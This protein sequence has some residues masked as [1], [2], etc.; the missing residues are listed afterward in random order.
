MKKKWL[1]LEWDA[2][3]NWILLK[4]WNKIAE[5]IARI[6]TGHIGLCVQLCGVIQI[7]FLPRSRLM[8]F[9][10]GLHPAG[11][12]G[13]ITNRMLRSLM[14]SHSLL[15]SSQPGFHACFFFFSLLSIFL[16]FAAN[17]GSASDCP[18]NLF[19]FWNYFWFL[20]L[21]WDIASV[22][23]PLW[24]CCDKQ[25][26]CGIMVWPNGLVCHVMSCV[27]EKWFCAFVCKI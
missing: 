18:P 20:V 9:Q 25:E 4:H 27:L 16:L 5:V 23:E 17:Q 12:S 15:P 2:F 3:K 1:H 10:I 8:L 13:L 22:K 14:G 6:R 21:L 24:G 19:F 26:A 11:A 7:V